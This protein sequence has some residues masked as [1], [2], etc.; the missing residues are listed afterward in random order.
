MTL[1]MFGLGTTEILIIV[2][3]AL[4]FIGPSKLPEFARSLGKGM[5]ELR[6]VGDEFQREM[7]RAEFED[8]YPSGKAPGRPNGGPGAKKPEATAVVPAPTGS[9]ADHAAP[10]QSAATQ[11]DAAQPGHSDATTANAPP[12]SPDPDADAPVDLRKSSIQQ[13]A[14]E[15]TLARS[16]RF[17]ANADADSA[18][19]SGDAD[20]RTIDPGATAKD[21][22]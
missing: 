9:V 20:L 4:I 14:P 10:G 17:E 13:K 18:A 11:S 12:V 2:V 6:K 15:G 22:A 7:A 3:V 1:A 8:E 21:P 19:G 5:R 16:G